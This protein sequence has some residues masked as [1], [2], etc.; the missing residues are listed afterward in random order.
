MFSRK[1]SANFIFMENLNMGKILSYY[2]SIAFFFILKPVKKITNK[3]IIFSIPLINLCTVTHTLKILETFFWMYKKY[4]KK[5]ACNREL[6]FHC[7][8][9]VL[10]KNVLLYLLFEFKNIRNQHIYIKVLNEELR[11]AF[12]M[13]IKV[14]ST[15]VLFLLHQRCT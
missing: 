14:H 1:N 8:L 7:T 9:I 3:I 6:I 12:Q 10:Q 13:L 11:V 4:R 15:K 2:K 5:C